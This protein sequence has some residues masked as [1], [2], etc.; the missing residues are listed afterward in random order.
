MI[1]QILGLTKMYN[2]YILGIFKTSH[3]WF[4]SKDSQTCNIYIYISKYPLT[5]IIITF[6][7][8]LLVY[9]FTFNPIDIS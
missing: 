8:N 4:V 1:D 6:F 9:Y 5:I 2:E 3:L 7:K